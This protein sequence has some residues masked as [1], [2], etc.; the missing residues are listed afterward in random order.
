MKRAKKVATF[1]GKFKGI[2][3]AASLRYLQLALKS[4]HRRENANHW[5]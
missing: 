1:L 4:R 5:R 2:P 3:A